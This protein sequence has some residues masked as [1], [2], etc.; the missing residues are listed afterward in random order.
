MD[1]ILLYVSNAVSKLPAAIR[2]GCE[3]RGQ[4]ARKN[5]TGQALEP[6]FYDNLERRRLRIFNVRSLVMYLS[7]K[8][9]CE[10]S[11]VPL[12]ATIPREA[13]QCVQKIRL[14]IA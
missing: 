12:E 5:T 13:H 14:F 8:D 4:E 11:R 3:H 10:R 9:L 6:R 7:G 1:I 2:S